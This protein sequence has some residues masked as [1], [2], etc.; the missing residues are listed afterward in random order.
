MIEP[1]AMTTALVAL[2]LLE[3]LIHAIPL[4]FAPRV[5][6]VLGR[7]AYRCFAWRSAVLR[8]NSRT[9][10]KRSGS[11]DAFERAAFEHLG[12]MLTLAL[13]P[14]SRNADLQRVTVTSPGEPT[15]THAS[16]V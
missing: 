3:Q 2:T 11:A 8:A 5:G 15:V 1:A 12:R 4:R 13:Q 9:V 10:C 7:I 16:A 6:Q 14:P